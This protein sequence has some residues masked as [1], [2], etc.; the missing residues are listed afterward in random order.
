M[1]LDYNIGRRDLQPV[2]V[3]KVVIVRLTGRNFKVCARVSKL[4]AF[5]ISFFCGATSVE[6]ISGKSLSIRRVVS[7]PLPHGRQ[8][9][10][11][12]MPHFSFTKSIVFAKRRILRVI[13]V[14]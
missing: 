3:H 11:I 9:G 7:V 5:I 8:N 13:V 14:V 2:L 4:I 12:V 1:A 6:V 10:C